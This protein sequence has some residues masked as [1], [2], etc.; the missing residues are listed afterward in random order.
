VVR[1]FGIDL[2]ITASRLLVSTFGPGLDAELGPHLDA[3]GLIDARPAA[4]LL[5]LSWI[6]HPR[7][8]RPLDHALD[9]RLFGLLIEVVGGDLQSSYPDLTVALER[10]R[11]R[12]FAR[13][14][15]SPSVAARP[16]SS[17]TTRITLCPGQTSRAPFPATTGIPLRAA[18]RSSR[19][20]QQH[21]T[22]K[23]EHDGKRERQAG[24]LNDTK[25]FLVSPQ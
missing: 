6:A 20:S 5:E 9:D 21:T 10:R 1:E 14:A 25:L 2:Q 24:A 13:G 7:R 17:A 19:P 23:Y 22:P 8:L 12:I 15:S 3:L 18:Y 11:Q 4:V 16:T